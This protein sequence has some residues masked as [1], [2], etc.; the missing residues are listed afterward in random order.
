MVWAN[1]RTALTEPED[2]EK[3]LNEDEYRRLDRGETPLSG[4]VVIYR[5]VEQREITRV[6][7][8]VTI[9]CDKAS[10]VMAIW[11]LSKWSATYGEDFHR[12]QDVYPSRLSS[13]KSRNERGKLPWS[14]S[15]HLSPA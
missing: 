1:R 4:D 9:E 3:I 15:Q 14:A 6:A 2:W 12:V 7:R 5:N 10:E 11:A 8:I 13:A